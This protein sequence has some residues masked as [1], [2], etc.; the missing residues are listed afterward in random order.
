MLL[1]VIDDGIFARV[2]YVIYSIAMMMMMMM[3]IYND[4]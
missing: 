2:C 4:E 1:L 3:M